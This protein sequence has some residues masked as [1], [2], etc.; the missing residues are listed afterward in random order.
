MAMI[1]PL[2]S[3]PVVNVKGTQEQ[4][5]VPAWEAFVPHITSAMSANIREGSRGSC[6]PV[7]GSK[8]HSPD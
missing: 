1:G 6:Y 8:D 2:I 5:H 4:M 7:F 3:F